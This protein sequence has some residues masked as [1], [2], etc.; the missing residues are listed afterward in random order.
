[1][2]T[3]PRPRDLLP[4]LGV[5]VL[6]LAIVAWVDLF[7]TR[8]LE[9]WH[10]GPPDRRWLYVLTWSKRPFV[11]ATVAGLFVAAGAAA[12]YAV[13]DGG[14]R[15]AALAI[16]A[17]PVA[18]WLTVVATLYPWGPVDELGSRYAR[19]YAPALTLE[20]GALAGLALVA[21]LTVAELRARRARAVVETSCVGAMLAWSVLVLRMR[22][23]VFMRWG[24]P[25]AWWFEPPLDTL[26]GLAL[27]L[28]VAP[29][30]ATAVARR[31]NSGGRDGPPH[32]AKTRSATPPASRRS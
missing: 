14:A 32:G 30:I 23:L 11:F 28:A 26:A 24:D 7:G 4:W 13:W 22:R 6:P 3:A 27:A 2:S 8:V 31:K 15:R 18:G 17:A 1:M 25:G 21:L 19:R 20:L 29:L 10:L 9:V 12:A 16:G 5:A